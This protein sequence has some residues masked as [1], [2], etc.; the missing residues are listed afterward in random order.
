MMLEFPAIQ[1]IPYLSE[2]GA[3]VHLRTGVELGHVLHLGPLL[4][5]VQREEQVAVHSAVHELPFNGCPRRGVELPAEH[6]RPVDEVDMPVRLGPGKVRVVDTLPT[7][8]SLLICL[9]SDTM[10]SMVRRSRKRMFCWMRFWS[11]ISSPELLPRSSG[12]PLRSCLAQTSTSFP[13]Y[14]ERTSSMPE[15]F[16]GM[17]AVSNSVRDQRVNWLPAFVDS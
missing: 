12:L 16:M 7:I 8:R 11:V 5:G 6:P 15:S 4:A 2:E 3:Q 9:L 17:D 10:L 14:C 13:R 1:D